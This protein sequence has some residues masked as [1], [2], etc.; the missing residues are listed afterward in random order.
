MSKPSAPAAPD[1]T[2]I[3]QADENI[4]NQQ[5]QLGQ[6]QLQWSQSQFNDVWPFAQDYLKQQDAASAAETATAKQQQQFYNTTYQ[7]IETQFANQA[8]SYNSPQR[9]SQAAGNAEADVASSFDANRS[10]AQS[11]LESYGIDPSQTRFGALDLGTRISQA[12]ATAAAGTQSHLNTEAT[13]LA[14]EGEAINVGRGYAGNV[15]G[16]YNTATNSG[17][18][19]INIA[20]NTTATGSNTMTQ[21]GTATGLG[22]NANAG[23]TGALSTGFSNSLAGTQFNGNMAANTSAGIGSLVGGA[24]GVAMMM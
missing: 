13:G 17:S 12:A 6:Q 15:A 5:F 9:A 18:S 14:L 3:A 4:A 10:A 7:P 16:A 8:T 21:A 2:P 22:L 19:G 1:Y 23:A 20:N 24:L 11:N